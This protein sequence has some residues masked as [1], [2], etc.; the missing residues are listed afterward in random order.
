LL[1]VQ[2]QYKKWTTISPMKLNDGY[3]FSDG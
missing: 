1:P 2:F 3:S